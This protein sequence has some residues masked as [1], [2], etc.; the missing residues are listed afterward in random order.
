MKTKH[1]EDQDILNE[2]KI[3]LKYRMPLNEYITYCEVKEKELQ[4]IKSDVERY[5]ELVI[6]GDS[7]EWIDEPCDKDEILTLEEKLKKAG[8]EL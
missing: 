6:S 1:E 3:P 4:G 7:L 5:L 2:T 8:K